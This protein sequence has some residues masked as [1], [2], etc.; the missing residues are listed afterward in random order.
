MSSERHSAVNCGTVNEVLTGSTLSPSEGWVM[1]PDD[2]KKA[3]GSHSRASKL[4]NAACNN[5]RRMTS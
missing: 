5:G 2:G 1:N 4:C 3:F